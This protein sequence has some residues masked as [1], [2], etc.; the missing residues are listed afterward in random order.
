MIS[1]DVNKIKNEDAMEAFALLQTLKHFKHYEDLF[2]VSYQDN[3]Y[4]LFIEDN[5][6]EFD[7]FRK[8]S[9]YVMSTFAKSDKELIDSINYKNTI[10]SLGFSNNDAVDYL[11]FYS[12]VQ[13]RL[14]R[15]K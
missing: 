5:M 10:V 15:S 9:N 7:S 14:L 8:L 4:L 3:K 6:Y 12:N 1:I 11:S 2:T 13:K